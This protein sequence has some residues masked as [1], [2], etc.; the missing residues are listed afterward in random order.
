ML[1]KKASALI[2]ILI[3]ASFMPIINA[4]KIKATA[5][6]PFFTIYL[7][8][9]KGQPDRTEWVIRISQELQ[10]IGI[11]TTL[12]LASWS[13]ISS[14]TW[15]YPGPY[16]IPTH[17]EGGYDILFVGWSYGL[18][19]N[20]IGWFDSPSITPYGDNFYQY[21]NPEMDWAIISNYTS[22]FVFDDRI[23][24]AKQIQAILYE[25]LPQATIFYPADLYP[26]DPNLVGW[27]PLLWE[28]DFQSMENWSISCQT[29]FHYATRYQFKHFH[30][31]DGFLSEND[32]QWLHQIYTG[33]IERAPL[34][35]YDYSPR[36]ATSITTTD[37]YTYNVELNPNATWYGFYGSMFHIGVM[38]RDSDLL[39]DTNERYYFTNPST[40]DTDA[41]LILDGY[42]VLSSK[43]D[44]TIGDMDGDGL[45]D[46]EEFYTHHT[47]PEDSDSDNDM[48]NDYEEVTGTHCYITDPL[49]NDTDGDLL[50][51]FE[52]VTLGDDGYITN[53]LNTDTDGDGLDDYEE[54]RYGFDG[55]ETNPTNPDTD[56]DTYSDYEEYLAGTDPTDPKDYPGVN[57]SPSTSP[58][59]T[60]GIE[61]KI[62]IPSFIIT[63]LITMSLKRTQ[64]KARIMKKQ[65]L[66]C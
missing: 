37:G 66:K 54:S 59:Q 34:N 15:G 13:E 27:D 21:E 4:Q 26:H 7:L 61:L 22:S 46:G 64:R 42:E 19:F 36:L 8:C 6:T 35:G 49:N 41:D 57:P 51:D 10:Q 65:K 55:Y 32:A 29:K 58:T 33:L 2:I 38:D 1:N 28:L 52:E 62:L 31:Y 3:S 53:P 39:D 30:I 40:N 20:P 45:L 48:L 12:I 16:P 60:G 11:E 47:N 18:D 9:P 43:T 63:F 25:D 5:P 23:Y 56:N 17:A 44:A 14:R 24:W 50:T